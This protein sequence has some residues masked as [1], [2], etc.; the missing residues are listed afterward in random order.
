MLS[1]D[2]DR[3]SLRQGEELVAR[4]QAYEPDGRSPVLLFG[5]VRADGSPVYGSHSD[6]SG[7]APTPA[8]DHR[9]AFGVRF[10]RVT[11]LPGKYMLRM[12]VLDPEGLR[13]FDTLEKE[14]V[15]TGETRDYGLARLEHEWV[16]VAD[17]R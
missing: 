8:G 4:A 1:L 17:R 6:E 11:L 9:F 12:H 5:I 16:A 3:A 10:P 14:F 15:V 7:F 13:L 2:L